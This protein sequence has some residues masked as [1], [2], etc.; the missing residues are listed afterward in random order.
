MG[1]PGCLTAVVDGNVS[2][3]WLRTAVGRRRRRGLTRRWRGS[4]FC[5]E[6]E[7]FPVEAEEFALAEAGVQGEFEQGVQRVALCGGE[8]LAGFVG[9][10]RFEASGPWGAGADAAGDVARDLLLA[11]GVLQDGLEHGVDVG[12]CRRGRRF[13]AVLPDLPELNRPAAVATATTPR[14]HGQP[15]TS[16]DQQTALDLRKSR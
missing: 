9:G 11:D 1:P 13:A 2:G 7:V 12:R 10:E 14:N 4:R 6:V 5:V 15:R 8:E 3:R 16:P